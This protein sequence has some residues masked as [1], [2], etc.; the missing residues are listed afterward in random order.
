MKAFVGKSFYPED[1]PPFIQKLIK[2]I[3]SH[4]INCGDA[5]AARAKPIDEKITELINECDVFVGIFSRDELI[6]KEIKKP[7]WYCKPWSKNQLF[8]TSDWVI[9]ESGFALGKGKLLILLKENGIRDLPKL[10]GNWEYIPFD[11]NNPEASFLKI[12]ETINAI[13]GKWESG[14]TVQ[15]IEMAKKTAPDK[16]KDKDEVTSQENNV[17][18]AMRKIKVA[19]WVKK[20][21]REAQK[22]FDDEIA[23]LSDGEIKDENYAYILRISH[24][25]GD[26]NAFNKLVALAEVKNTPSIILELAYRYKEMREYER[27]K[28]YFVLSAEKY[29]VNN[30]ENLRASII[31]WTEAAWCLALDGNYDEAINNLKQKLSNPV[32]SKNQDPILE[33]MAEISKECGDIEHFLLYA[34]SALVYKPTNTSLRF[35]LAYDYNERNE[36]GLAVLHY[37]KLMSTMKNPTAMNNLGVAYGNLELKYKAIECYRQAANDKES[38]ALGNLAHLYLEK[39]FVND[40]QKQIDTANKLSNDNIRP[41]P[42]VGAAQTKIRTLIED[43]DRK[44]KNILEF[45]EKQRKFIVRY[46]QNLLANKSLDDSNIEGEWETS[47]GRGNLTFNSNKKFFNIKIHKEENKLSYAE[48]LFSS[49]PLVPQPTKKITTNINIEGK[50]EG[51]VGKYTV[52][53]HKEGE[54]PSLLKESDATGHSIFNEKFDIIQV[55]EKVKDGDTKFNEWK[56]LSNQGS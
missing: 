8:T 46:S 52:Q 26:E 13:R 30:P 36:N 51:M 29:D 48:I 14:A 12:S 20:D 18:T 41:D 15:P 16:L 55:M 17:K 49:G 33:A 35:R 24:S 10:Q 2:F 23:P 40:A 22:I 25:L 4:G 45:A 44:E 56:K 54:A 31:P 38:I 34:E 50:F 5:E 32:F 27:A 53:I 42:R 28:K 11:R 19:L 39:G 47:W 9:Q 37:K 6:C 7:K 1:E 3:E 43:E 21:Y